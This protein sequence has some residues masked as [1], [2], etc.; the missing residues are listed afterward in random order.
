MLKLRRRLVTGIRSKEKILR[1]MFTTKVSRFSLERSSL[2][3]NRIALLLMNLLTLVI[4]LFHLSSLFQLGLLEVFT[5]SKREIQENQRL[6][7]DTPSWL[8]STTT[9]EL[10][11]DTRIS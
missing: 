11:S 7:L 2:S 9:M 4:I 5:G 1:E 8:K 3:S 6:R 10:L